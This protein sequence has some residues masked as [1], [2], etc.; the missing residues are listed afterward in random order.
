M[1]KFNYIEFYYKRA[2]IL[3]TISVNH[4]QPR[5]ISEIKL[6]FCRKGFISFDKL[7]PCCLLYF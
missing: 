6:T 2:A 3:N 5:L 7:L 4:F 1:N